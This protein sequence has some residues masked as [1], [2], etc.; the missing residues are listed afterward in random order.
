MPPSIGKGHGVAVPLPGGGINRYDAMK[1]T[2]LP[3]CDRLA[4]AA[5]SSPAA[6][7]FAQG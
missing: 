4:D 6:D 2:K 5:A 1:K 7:Y 3:L